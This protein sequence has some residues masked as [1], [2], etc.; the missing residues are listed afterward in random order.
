M[1]DDI[2]KEGKKLSTV[3]SR[4]GETP[5]DHF[6]YASD[7]ERKE[8]RGLEDWELV[9]KIPESQK[10]VPYWFLAVV[11]TVLLVAVGLSFPFWGNRPGYERDWVDWGFVAALFYV[12]AAGAFVHFMVQLYGSS[13]GGKLDSDK[14]SELK[15]EQNPRG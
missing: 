5:D 10:K 15:D 7:A 14:D 12:A 1:S 4:W 6:G 2:G 8:K 11:V 13:T 3:E 9:E